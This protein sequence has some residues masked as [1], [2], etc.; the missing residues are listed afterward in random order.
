[1]NTMQL[2][3]INASTEVAF[4]QAAA[5]GKRRAKRRKV[6]QHEEQIKRLTDKFQDGDFSLSSLTE[7]R[8]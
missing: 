5:G 1:M 2:F 6:V 4:E 8:R 3:T 7:I